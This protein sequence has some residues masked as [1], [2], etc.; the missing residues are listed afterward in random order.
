M[1]DD[2]L[3]VYFDGACPLCRREIAF[4][5]RQRGGDR[6]DWRDISET[7]AEEVAPGLSRATALKRFHVTTADARTRSG[8]AA[9]AALWMAIPRFAWAGRIMALPGIRH[10]LD[11][12]YSG[13]LLVRPMLQ[14]FARRWDAPASCAVCHRDKAP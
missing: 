9:F 5:Q 4:Y 12:A 6:I 14:R 7:D 13:F 1:S 3:T 11:V 8:A 2:R 10:I